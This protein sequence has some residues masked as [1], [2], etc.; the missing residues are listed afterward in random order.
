MSGKRLRQ[1]VPIVAA[2]AV[3]LPAPLLRLLEITGTAHP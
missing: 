3:A 1:W 2:A